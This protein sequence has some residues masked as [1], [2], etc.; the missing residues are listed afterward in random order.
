M[1]V[2]LCPLDRKSLLSFVSEWPRSSHCMESRLVCSSCV[3]RHPVPFT[4]ILHAK[5]MK[6]RRLFWRQ[7]CRTRSSF[8]FRWMDW[9]SFPTCLARS[10]AIWS[11]SDPWWW[12][13]P[14]S[15]R[16]FAIA[17]SSAWMCTPSTS[18]A[19]RIYPLSYTTLLMSLPPISVTR[20]TIPSLPT[21]SASWSSSRPS[22]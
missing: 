12:N 4:R 17:V 1:G 3:S 18:N 2:S 16:S 7:V 8:S 20:S 6:Q 14:R 5:A 15:Y 10:W 9:S 22:F 19:R 11:S 13:C 21:E